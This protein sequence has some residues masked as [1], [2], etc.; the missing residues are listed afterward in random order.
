LK[1]ELGEANY[2]LGM[3]LRTQGK[4][5]EAEQQLRLAIQYHSE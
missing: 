1:P 4:L 5:P 2:R 3:A